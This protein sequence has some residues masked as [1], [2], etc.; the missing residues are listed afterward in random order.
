MNLTDI[1]DE[2]VAGGNFDR[3]DISRI[4][5]TADLIVAHD[6]NFDRQLLERVSEVFRNKPWAC[7]MSQIDLANEDHEGTRP[8]YLLADA[9]Y[10]YDRHRAESDCIAAIELLRTRLKKSGT[11]TM[12]RLLENARKATWRLWAESSPYDLKDVLKSRG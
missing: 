11:S 5:Q 9:G 8:P 4:A 3:K 10:F 12:A 6:A 7:S 2:M 1:T